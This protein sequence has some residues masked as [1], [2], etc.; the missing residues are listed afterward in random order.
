M[1]KLRQVLAYSI[2]HMYAGVT[3]YQEE[4]ICSHYEF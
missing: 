2:N 3:R 4:N 1:R